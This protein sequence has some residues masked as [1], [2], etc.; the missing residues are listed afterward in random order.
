MASI[1]PL[2]PGAPAS[3]DQLRGVVPPIVTPLYADGDV[4]FDSLAR[5]VERHLAAGVDALF[6]LGSSGEAVFMTSRNRRAVLEA[7][8][9]QVAGRVPVLAGV[10]DATAPRVIEHVADAR[11]AGVNAVVATA[12][13]YVRTSPTEIKNHFRIIKDAAGEL[14]LLAYNIPVS[15]HEVLAIPD[16]MELGAEG[17]LAGV[18]DSGGS[19]SYTRMLCDART[20][21]EL[22]DFLVLTGSETTVD[23]DYLAGVDGVVPGLANVDPVGYVELARTLA[24]GD[25]AKGRAQQARLTELMGIAGVGDAPRMGGSAAGVGS[26]KVA[27]EHLGVLSSRTMFPPHEPF[28]DQQVAQIAAIVDAA[29]IEEAY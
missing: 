2:T 20:H 16:I 13:Y 26:F 23:M 22:T 17:T 27:L 1:A 28:T 14:P 6:A 12:P 21:A 19:D 7:V 18:K 8:V 11:Y 10:I 25:F 15:V 4:D 29:E 5:L 24:T 9:D 3:P